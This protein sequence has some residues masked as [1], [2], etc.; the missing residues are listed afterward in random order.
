MHIADEEGGGKGRKK[1]KAKKE[2]DPNAPK[3]AKTAYSELCMHVQTHGYS[4]HS[5]CVL[6]KGIKSGHP[7]RAR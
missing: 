4:L 5:V 7:V 3:A 6:N 2:K 1:K